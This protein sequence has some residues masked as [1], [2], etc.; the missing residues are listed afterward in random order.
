MRKEHRPFYLKKSILN[1][2]E[3]YTHRF[4]E[5]QFDQLGQGFSFVKPW[6]VKIFGSNIE[7][8]DYV[9]V[10]ADSDMKVRLTVWSEIKGKGR[11]KVGNY[12]LICPGVR[13]SSAEE[14]I[15]EDNCMLASRA[16]IT[17]SDWHDTYDRIAP[18]GKMAPIKL[19]SNVL[20][21]DSA[22]VCKGVTIGENSI[23]GAGAVVVND[24]PANS[25][26]AGNPAKVVKKL[27]TTKEMLTR[28]QYYAFM[29][30]F[31]SALM[32]HNNREKLKGNTISGWLRSILSPRKSD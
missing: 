30:S 4:L 28:D 21:G 3:F 19:E 20:I 14:I 24:V 17:D 1:F 18:I 31:P 25:I 10:I 7:F 29:H 27:D 23:V 22:I 32:D 26:A 5:P 15:I 16:Y 8:G 12:C 11:I 9:N 2:Q 13:I 6:Y